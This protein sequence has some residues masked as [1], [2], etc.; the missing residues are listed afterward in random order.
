MSKSREALK[1][2]ITSNLNSVKGIDANKVSDLKTKEIFPI[3]YIDIDKIKRNKYNFYPI[4][5]TD[6]LAEDIKQNGLSHNIVVRKSNEDYEIISG[7]RRFTA[8]TKLYNE[9]MKE[10]SK[11]PCKVV[12]VDDVQAMI[13]LIQANAQSREISE[14]IKLKQVQLLHEL[15]AEQNNN[16]KLLTKE[17]QLE[18][19]EATKMSVS[20]V[21]KYSSL[22][23]SS[24]ELKDAFANE[25][26]N[27]SEATSISRLSDEGQK[28]AVEIVKNVEDKIDVEELKSDI[29]DIEK[30]KKR[31]KISDSELKKQLDVIKEKY[32]KTGKSDSTNSEL[33]KELSLS[34]VNKNMNHLIKKGEKL[35]SDI[36]NLEKIDKNLIDKFTTLEDIVKGIKEEIDLVIKNN[37]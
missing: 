19:A 28:L 6:E 7:E 11:I 2:K 21:K 20:Q 30:Q 36:S 3:A 14:M 31:N 37:Q 33:S 10:F 13:L 9:G 17:I 1:S 16:K 35:I 8:L 23:N 32:V 5:N 26:L 22:A 25:K 34:T 4:E 24:E 15:Y 18:I 27:F 29:K 12:D